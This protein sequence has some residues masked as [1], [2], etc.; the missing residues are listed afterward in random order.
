[1]KQLKRKDSTLSPTFSS[2]PTLKE[3]FATVTVDMVRDGVCINLGSSCSG[4]CGDFLVRQNR[5][6]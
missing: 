2:T 6:S 1:M 3:E 5:S 4:E